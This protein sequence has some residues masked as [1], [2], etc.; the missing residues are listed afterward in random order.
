MRSGG[1]R[2]EWREEG[3]VEGGGRS[4]GRSGGRRE[5]WREEEGEVVVTYSVHVSELSF[6]VM[7]EFF[8]T[9][10]HSIALR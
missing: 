10:I 9:N 1:R 5:E 6:C 2:E 4:G 8:S 3:G 7:I